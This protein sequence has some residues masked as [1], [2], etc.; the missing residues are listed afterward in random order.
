MN[1]CW[2]TCRPG[3][4]PT[5]IRAPPAPISK[6]TSSAPPQE[7]DAFA[8]DYE[9]K[10][11]GLDG[12]TL[13]AAVARFEALSDLM[14]RIG[15]YAQL[16]Y[17]QDQADPQARAVLAERVGEADRHRLE[18]AVLRPRAE[19][20]RGR[21]P[22]RQA[23]GSRARQVRAVAARRAPVPAAPA[24]RRAREVPARPVGGRQQRLVAPVRRDDRAAALSVP[25][26]DA[27]RA[28]DPR[29]AV[30]QGRRACARTPPNPSARCRATTSRSSR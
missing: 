14:G 5:S 11:A 25:Q 3:T 15:S 28:A 29:Q 6:P 21:R 12:K 16:Y 9:G 4:S 20:D 22:R 2:A 1:A 18:A 23:E 7:A 26:R 19:Q 30:E 24:L 8:K 27:E 10:V 13:G 17:A